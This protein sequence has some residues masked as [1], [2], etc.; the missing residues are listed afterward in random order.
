MSEALVDAGYA[1]HC[2][3]E[4]LPA[5]AASSGLDLTAAIIDLGLPDCSGDCAPHWCGSRFVTLD[6]CRVMAL[7]LG[8]P[9]NVSLLEQIV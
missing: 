4:G 5:L 1:V 7:A 6:E 3:Y 9:V 2:E 8:W